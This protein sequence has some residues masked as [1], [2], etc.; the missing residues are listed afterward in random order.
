MKILVMGLPNSGKT[1]FAKRLSEHLRCAWFNADDMRKMAND[2]DF[3]EVG[4]ERMA[5]RMCWVATFERMNG[6]PVVC[7][8]ICPTE[9]TRE[10]FGAD[11]VIYMDTIQESIYKDTNA[12]F[13][14]PKSPTLRIDKF[15]CD[16]GIES[17]INKIKQLT[18][19][20]QCSIITPQ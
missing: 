1:H 11:I 5:A 7:D 14:P 20:I 17:V 4:R 8:F 18:A 15:L 12:V 16:A 2:W 6:R 9:K 19:N 3:S 10:I 13:V